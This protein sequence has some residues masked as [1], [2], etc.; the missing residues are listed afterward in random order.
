MVDRLAAPMRLPVVLATVSAA[1]PASAV[2]AAL[3]ERYPEVPTWSLVHAGDETLPASLLQAQFLA[4]RAGAAIWVL[5]DLKPAAEL[6]AAAHVD[7]A[8]NGRQMELSR[9]ADP[10]APSAEHL[11]PCAGALTLL[12]DSSADS[13]SIRVGRW[14]IAVRSRTD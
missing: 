12:S 5:V 4:A 1:T 14:A 13:V 8:E 6:A 9:S 7:A 2:H 3:S 10:A 11:N